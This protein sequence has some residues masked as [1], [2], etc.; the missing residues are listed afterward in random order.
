[1]SSPDSTRRVTVPISFIAGA[2]LIIV[3]VVSIAGT[4]AV[5]R[6]YDA[7]HPVI[8]AVTSI[9]TVSTTQSE[10]SYVTVT[11]NQTLSAA[12]PY[13]YLYGYGANCYPAGCVTNGYSLAQCAGYR[14]LQSGQS[15]IAGSLSY[16][17]TCLLMYDYDDGITY[18]LFGYGAPVGTP[19]GAYSIAVGYVLTPSYNSSPCGGIP[20]QVSYFLPA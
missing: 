7:S 11:Q 16:Q 18:V 14:W 3:A 12:G 20:F 13:A 10:T 1:L 8:S 5:T 19:S 4:Y 17:G 9:S 2:L 6:S 15:C